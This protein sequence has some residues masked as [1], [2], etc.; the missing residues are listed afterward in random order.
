MLKAIGKTFSSGSS[1][2]KKDNESLSK[3]ESND[4]INSN[5]SSG[6]TTIDI[7]LDDVLFNLSNAPYNLHYFYQYCES[8]NALELL[9]FWIACL[10]VRNMFEPKHIRSSYTMNNWAVPKSL[11]ERKHS[12]HKI[13]DDDITEKEKEEVK[14]KIMQRMSVKVGDRRSLARSIHNLQAPDSPLLTPKTTQ[15]KKLRD[16]MFAEAQ[17]MIIMCYLVDDAPLQVNISATMRNKILDNK[18][19]DE[20]PIPGLFDEAMKET[21]KLI[22]QNY[23]NKFLLNT[24]KN[25]NILPS[26]PN[27]RKTSKTL[28][29]LP[30]GPPPSD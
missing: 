9:D 20:K 21:E 24:K 28:P 22:S 8:M 15:K 10:D 11:E 3:Q 7:E 14:K 17:N 6:A 25:N 18:P 2:K 13:T 23:F 26:K 30:P 12:K 29:P 27:K 19:T 16:H 1:N 4:S 5:T